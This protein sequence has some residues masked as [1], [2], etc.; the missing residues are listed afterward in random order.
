MKFNFTTYLSDQKCPYNHSSAPIRSHKISNKSYLHSPFERIKCIERRFLGIENRIN[1]YFGDL[2]LL[3]LLLFSSP[4][5]FKP[6]FQ[7]PYWCICGLKHLST[8]I[9]GMSTNY[10]TIHS[11]PKYSIPSLFSMPFT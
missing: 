10:I 9:Y 1:A 6:V 11:H 2:L 5:A 3:Q 4:V 7:Q 8:R